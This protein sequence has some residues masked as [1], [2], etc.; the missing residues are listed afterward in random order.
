M[1]ARPSS[2]LLQVTPD[3]TRPVHDG[4]YHLL[5]LHPS[6]MNGNIGVLLI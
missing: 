2:A 5:R 6:G 1:P 3:E 4:L